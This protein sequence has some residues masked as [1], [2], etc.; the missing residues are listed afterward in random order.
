MA[1]E[2]K[3]SEGIGSTSNANKLKTSTP[4]G[5]FYKTK[6]LNI[7]YDTNIVKP[8]AID[9]WYNVGVEHVIRP[10][11]KIIID[12]RPLSVRN[13][14]DRL[15]FAL[16]FATKGVIHSNA[17]N[18][19]GM[20]MNGWDYYVNG[21]VYCDN[22]HVK[23]YCPVALNQSLRLEFHQYKIN[24]FVQNKN[25]V[26]MDVSRIFTE[27]KDK[28]FYPSLSLNGSGLAVQIIDFKIQ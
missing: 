20:Y 16:G 21:G 5:L 14:D 26:T 22:K 27:N 2:S 12:I 17:H 28:Q 6:L 24:V 13:K 10:K 8:T 7:C 25:V 9:G 23:T 3:Q 4:I 19:V 11:E 15:Y 1:Q 18:H